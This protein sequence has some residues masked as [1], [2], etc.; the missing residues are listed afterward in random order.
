MYIIAVDDEFLSRMDIEWAIRNAVPEAEL[1]CFEDPVAALDFV[2][3]NHVDVAYLD[4]RMPEMSGLELAE[5]I[6][7]I[8]PKTNIIFSTGYDEYAYDAFSVQASGYL[9]KPI[10]KEAIVQ[11]LANLRLPVAKGEGKMHVKCFGNFDVFIEGTPVHFPRQKAKELLAYLI[12]K[13]GTSCTTREICAAIYE[14]GE[15]FSALDKQ[16]QTQISTMMKALKDVGADDVIVKRR[17]SLAIDTSKVDCDYYGFLARDPDAINL[18]MGEYMSNYSWAEF[19]IDYLDSI[20]DK[21]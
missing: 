2:R 14:D 18:Y 21:G 7:E 15:N 13:R 17:N 4:I 10:T 12:H 16:I 5:K 11:S 20:L 1:L 19:K 8:S 6:R 3:E 9:L